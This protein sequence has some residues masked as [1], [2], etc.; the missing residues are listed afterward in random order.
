MNFIK[1]LLNVIPPNQYKRCVVIIATMFIGALMDSIG[2]GAILPLISAMGND[3]YLFDHQLIAKIVGC[4]GIKKHNE[5]LI[6]MSVSLIAMYI[7][8]NL[9]IALCI[10][11]QLSF[12][13]D[14]QKKYAVALMERYLDKP[15][16]YHINKNSAYFLRNISNG[17]IITFSR[18][19]TSIFTIITEICTVFCI[20]IVIAISDLTTA[21]VT[22]FMFGVMA[23][24]LSSGFKNR[25]SQQ[26]KIQNKYMME[27]MK[28]I[29]QGFGAI[30]DI[31]IMHKSDYFLAKFYKVYEMF[32]SADKIYGFLSQ[33][34]RL[35]IETSSVIILLIFII[36]KII[37]GTSPADLVS[38]LGVLALAAFRLM[39]SANRILA[40]LNTIKYHMAN[41]NDIYGELIDIKEKIK[42]DSEKNNKDILTF[43]NIIEINHLQFQYRK[44][45]KYVLQDVSFSIPKGSF[46]GIIGESG[47]GKTTFVDILLGLM[48]PTNGEIYVDDIN[49][50]DNLVNWQK[51]LAYVP[52][53]IYLIDGTILEN[54]A[55]GIN[56]SDIDEANVIR[57]LKM[58]QLYDFISELPN[59][60]KTRVGERGVMLSGGQRQRI[61]IARALYKNPQILILD[62]ATSA[63]D[64]ETE[65][66]ITDTILA[67]KGQLTIIAIAHR[68]TT[69]VD[70]DFKVK[71]DGG[72]AQIIY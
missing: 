69:L 40:S 67:L 46:V 31:K 37:L 8:K 54:I 41:F 57:V 59:G 52:Q 48:T 32:T 17:P 64:N 27:Y 34:P 56:D 38:L 61:G 4:L 30:K 43:N 71:F 24:L 50:S 55:L 49:I 5:F 68:L 33:L 29:Q 53:S 12:T 47:A 15:Y 70:C 39:P 23:L 9:F 45:E 44:E 65:K 72:K 26:G 21:V 3:N 7:I 11:I 14:N 51:L 1:R 10:K 13:L 19:F 60:L 58:A 35:I 28:W 42:L 16:L 6:F 36:M 18:M 20:W 25:I 2:I 62:E 22:L 63:L 66:S